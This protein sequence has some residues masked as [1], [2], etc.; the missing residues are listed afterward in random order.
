MK[1]I[2]YIH[3]IFYFLQSIFFSGQKKKKIGLTR[4][5]L[6]VDLGSHLA[7]AN[8]RYTKWAAMCRSYDYHE[9]KKT[10]KKENFPAHEHFIV[11]SWSSMATSAKMKSLL[12][13]LNFLGLSLAFKFPISNP[14]KGC[15]YKPEF[16]KN[17]AEVMWV[18]Q[19]I[20]LNRRNTSIAFENLMESTKSKDWC[21]PFC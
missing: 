11:G 15:C 14:I 3:D 12:L 10:I 16:D 1:K 18:F 2:T 5:W 9:D 8:W 17:I 4:V 7:G 13:Y 6:E 20:T 19:L 21:G